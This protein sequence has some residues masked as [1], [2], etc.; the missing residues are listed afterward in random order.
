MKNIIIVDKK[1]HSIDPGLI[2]KKFMAPVQQN[3][4]KRNT[5]H[6]QMSVWYEL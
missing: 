5:K 1:N 6:L 3:I 2:G 4:T